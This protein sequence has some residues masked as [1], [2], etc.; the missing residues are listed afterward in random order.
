[1]IYINPAGE[2]PRHI[3]DIQLEYPDF[4]VG[5]KLPDG[6]I[7]VIETGRPTPVE[8]KIIYEGY[9]EEINGVMTQNWVIRDMTPEEIEKKE[10]PKTAKEKLIAL[11]L[12]E[13]EVEALVSGLI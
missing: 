12:T 4:K 8:N 9:P 2:Y 11:G 3:G 1:M 10:A 5:D 13:V 6:W 7:E